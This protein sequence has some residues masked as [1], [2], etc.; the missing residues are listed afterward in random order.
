MIHKVVCKAV[1]ML[2]TYHHLY[3]HNLFSVIVDSDWFIF[4]EDNKLEQE[5]T[6]RSSPQEVGME[7]ITMQS[8]GC[9]WQ[10]WALMG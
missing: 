8:L 4:P 7:H 5:E 10:T 2:E 1:Y 3:D 6:K 9:F